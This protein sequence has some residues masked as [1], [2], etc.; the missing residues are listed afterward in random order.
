M[1]PEKQNNGL[2]TSW[3]EI[4]AYLKCGIRSCIRWEKERGLPVHRMAD[5]PGSRVFA[6]KQELDDWLVA[7]LRANNKEVVQ[8]RESAETKRRISPIWLILILPVVLGLFFVFKPRSGPAPFQ[9]GIYSIITTEPASP[10]RMRVWEA[11][12]S[13]TYKNTWGATSSRYNTVMHTT[14][15]AGD[16]DG[17]G[18]TELAAPTYVK[19]TVNRGEK[20]IVYFGIFVNFYKE[21]KRELWKTTFYSE[22]D[23]ITEEVDFRDNQVILSNLDGDPGNEIILKTATGLGV[24]DYKQDTGEIKLVA[25]THQPLKGRNL[26]LRSIAAARFGRIGTE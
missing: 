8:E 7:Q 19:I 25:V 14:I 17:D 20:E 23:H 6:Y 24:L 22:Q 10:G 9:T 12:K 5:T 15:A 4:S 11:T 3:K 26:G 2:L 21:G 18:T 1:E 13:G 16:I